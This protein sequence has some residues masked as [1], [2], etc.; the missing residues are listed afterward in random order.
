MSGIPGKCDGPRTTSR[1][2][3]LASRCLAH[4]QVA[5]NQNWKRWLTGLQSKRLQ[6]M[7][8]MPTKLWFKSKQDGC[9][10]MTTGWGGVAN[11]ADVM[12]ILGQ[13]YRN[14]LKSNISLFISA[15]NMRLHVDKCP[16][17]SEI[18]LLQSCSCPQ[19]PFAT[20]LSCLRWTLSL[21]SGPSSR[22][23]G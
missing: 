15:A 10:P 5:F 1:T 16:K 6:N 7:G 23:N 19:L 11:R 18:F 20:G 12:F 8:K 2:E 17:A 4:Q 21:A 13:M 3:C 22:K 9:F 14:T